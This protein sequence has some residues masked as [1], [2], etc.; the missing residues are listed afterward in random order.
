MEM[1]DKPDRLHRKIYDAATDFCV[2]RKLQRRAQ[3]KKVNAKTT[4]EED[5]KKGSQTEAE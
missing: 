5:N 4:K 2:A 3:R 1:T